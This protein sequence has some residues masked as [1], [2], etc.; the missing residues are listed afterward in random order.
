MLQ[1][2]LIGGLLAGGVQRRADFVM[3]VRILLESPASIHT[4]SS[5][6]I[7]ADWQTHH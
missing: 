5:A 4:V 7:T 6:A 3:T 1:P 2:E